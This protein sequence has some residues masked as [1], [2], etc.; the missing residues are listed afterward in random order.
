MKV[1]SRIGKH[2][3]AAAAH[4]NEVG[5]E[6]L[7]SNLSGCMEKVFSYLFPLIFSLNIMNE[8]RCMEL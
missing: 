3:V 1:V 5:K 2:V 4:K 7:S 8:D 6:V